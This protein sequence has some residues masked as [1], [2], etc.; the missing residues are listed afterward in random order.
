MNSSC[1]STGDFPSKCYFL[2]KLEVSYSNRGCHEGILNVSA[3]DIS[4]I[5]NCLGEGISETQRGVFLGVCFLKSSTDTNL[6][7]MLVA[8][9]TD[10]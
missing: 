9:I 2:K 3:T 4:H 7:V 5:P 1:F 8:Q 10:V 6:I